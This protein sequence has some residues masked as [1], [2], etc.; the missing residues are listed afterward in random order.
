MSSPTVAPDET[1][2]GVTWSEGVLEG[3]DAEDATFLDCTFDGLTISA[4]SWE[5]TSWR[6]GALT[7]VRVLGGRFARS[8]WR[9]VRFERTALAGCELLSTP[10]A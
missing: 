3:V 7:G 1:F 10:P 6:G 4:G 9:G 5:R 2:E 8:R